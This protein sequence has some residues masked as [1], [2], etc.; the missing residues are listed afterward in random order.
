MNE[1]QNY[2]DVYSTAEEGFGGRAWEYNVGGKIISG[3]EYTRIVT[4][5]FKI[6]MG[7][8]LSEGID[9]EA[10]KKDL[11]STVVALTHKIIGDALE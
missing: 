6:V 9:N 7:N 11:A 8:F 3:P 1:E 5:R 10:D 2:D 4:E